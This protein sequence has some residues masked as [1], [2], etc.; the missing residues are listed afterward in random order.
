M[1]LLSQSGLVAWNGQ[2]L[3]PLQPPAVNQSDRQVSDILV[4][5][6]E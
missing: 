4:E 1:H 2:S 6:R 3:E 5:M